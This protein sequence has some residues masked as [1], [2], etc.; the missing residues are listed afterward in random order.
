MFGS[1][2][3]AQGVEKLDKH[4][5]LSLQLNLSVYCLIMHAEK[6]SHFTQFK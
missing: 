4:F 1:G 5:P 2:Q 6:N 3:F